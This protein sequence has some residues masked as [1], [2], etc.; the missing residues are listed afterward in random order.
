MLLWIITGFYF[1]LFL[2]FDRMKTKKK[3]KK[4]FIFNVLLLT[5]WIWLFVLNSLSIYGDVL[6]SLLFWFV[7]FLMITY[8]H[9]LCLFILIHSFIH[10]LIL[11]EFCRSVF[12]L[13]K[14]KIKWKGKEEEWHNGKY[15]ICRQS[16]SYSWIVLDEININSMFVN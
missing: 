13:K 3:R 12:E 15:V 14:L 1:I 8:D 4:F 16:Y 7:R 6:S 9:I 10:S 11:S 5:L 2:Y